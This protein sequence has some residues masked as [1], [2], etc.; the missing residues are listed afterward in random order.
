MEILGGWTEQPGFPVHDAI[1]YGS[2]YRPGTR[3]DDRGS[4]DVLGECLP[5]SPYQLGQYALDLIA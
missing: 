5:C 4:I 3:S 1:F 2:F